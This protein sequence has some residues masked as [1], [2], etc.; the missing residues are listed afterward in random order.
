MIRKRVVIYLRLSKEDGDSESLSISNQRKILHEYAKQHNLEIV[1][2]YVDDGVSGYSMDRPALNK[3]KADLNKNMVQVILVKDLSR[4]GRNDAHVQLF[5]KNMIESDKQVLSLGENFDSTDENC[6]DTLGIHTWSNEKLIRDTSRKVRA[7]IKTLQKEGKWLCNIPYGYKKDDK[8]KYKYHIDETIAPYVKQIFDMYINGCGFNII[9]RKL[10]EANVP[11][12]NMVKKMYAEERGETYKRPVNTDWNVKTV[13]R[14]LK[15]EFYVGTLT[16]GR[17][18]RRSINGKSILQPEENWH[19]FENAHEALIDKATFNLAQ[20]IMVCRLQNPYRGVKAGYKQSIFAGLL[21]C[22]ECGKWMTSKSKIK[23]G[24]TFI[25]STYNAYG[26]AR[27]TSHS[28]ME[29]EIKYVLF[30]FLES[31]KTNL[32]NIIA[33]L[34]NIIQSELKTKSNTKDNISEIA[35]RIQDVKTSIEILITQ[36]MRETMKNPSMI[37]MIDKMY[38]DMLNTKYKEVQIL[39]K[40]LND[41]NKLATTEVELKQNL[42]SAISIIDEI[43]QS[44]EVSKKQVMMLIDKI[45]VHE[46]SGIDIYLKG[47]LHKICN[48]YFKV[49]R[50][51]KMKMKKIICDVISANPDKFTIGQCIE[52]VRAE[53]MTASYKSI[54]GILK[55]ELLEDNIIELKS[56]NHGYRLIGTNKDLERKLIFNPVADISR[57]LGNNNDI[58]EILMKVNDWIIESAYNK[59]YLF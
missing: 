53:G 41:Q 3:L 13:D 56:M 48:N 21:Y 27:C 33:D 45:I 47:D 52:K 9:A 50:T 28:I 42:N 30:E 7:S 36:K 2:E 44:E 46:D 8:H 35:T 57:C 54:S 40:Q 58:Y 32:T 20:D 18:K 49:E 5:I 29:K 4:L 51:K 43:L 19:V 11:T 10:T 17:Y 39:E 23:Y 22:N 24:K 59:K 12:P 6:L 26:V 55:K 25:C 14:I 34:D 31:C 1:D 16:T 37:D 15:N 38:D